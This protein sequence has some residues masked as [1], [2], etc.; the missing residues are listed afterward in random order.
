[1]KEKVIY[2]DSEYDAEGGGYIVVFAKEDGKVSYRFG[3]WNS[4]RRHRYPSKLQKRVKPKQKV[5]DK[6]WGGKN[7]KSFTLDSGSVDGW[8]WGII[9]TISTNGSFYNKGGIAVKNDG[10]EFEKERRRN[11]SLKYW[12]EHREEMLVKRK[13]Y[14]KE[15]QIHEREIQREYHKTHREEEK[16]YNERWKKNNPEKAKTLM[17]RHQHKRRRNL[18]FIPLNSSF[19]NSEAHHLD[20]DLVVYVPM[21]LHHS[22][23][24]NVFTGKGMDIINGK[25]LVWIGKLNKKKKEIKNENDKFEIENG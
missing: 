24:H 9:C 20:K 23:V 8:S 21:D 11:A 18:G 14:Y 2:S 5:L 3:G 25:V 6:S 10:T 22:V 16:K 1:M 13:A 19:V 7:S 4:K 12:H 15:H 17:K